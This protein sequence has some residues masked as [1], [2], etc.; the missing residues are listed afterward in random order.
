MVL[1]QYCEVSV[2]ITVINTFISRGITIST[3]V[4]D[5]FY[6][7]CRPKSMGSLPILLVLTGLQLRKSEQNVFHNFLISQL[8]PMM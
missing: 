3:K 2:I 6:K 5:F 1:S 7:Q 8:N 4:D